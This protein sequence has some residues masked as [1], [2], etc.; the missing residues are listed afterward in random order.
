MYNYYHS[1]GWMIFVWI[2]K[3]QTQSLQLQGADIELSPTLLHNYVL[4]GV[5][6]LCPHPVDVLQEETT[7]MMSI[8]N[9]IFPSSVSLVHNGR[10]F[11]LSLS[12]KFTSF[13]S[14]KKLSNFQL[15]P[16]YKCQKREDLCYLAH[17]VKSL[18]D[19]RY[20][21]KKSIGFPVKIF[22]SFLL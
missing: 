11:F 12:K 18:F 19:G 6:V 20:H 16:I 15:C 17:H 8:T 2:R 4:E 5:T 14:G 7:P 10:K 1:A 22:K 21:T 3:P 9:E 13:K